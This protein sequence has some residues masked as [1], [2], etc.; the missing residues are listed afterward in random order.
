[1]TPLQVLI[2]AAVGGA[3]GSFGLALVVVCALGMLAASD[4]LAAR[5]R[6]RRTRR[7]ARSDDLSTCR[8]IG[9]LGTHDPDHQQP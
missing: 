2:V 5:A 7:R 8:A 6:S 9:A 1:M 3:I 4:D